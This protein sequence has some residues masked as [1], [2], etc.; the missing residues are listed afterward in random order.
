ML[1]LLLLLW[2]FSRFPDKR[3]ANA[4][5]GFDMSD[6]TSTSSGNWDEVARETLAVALPP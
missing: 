5:L 3:R 6:S 4:A 2:R 1:L